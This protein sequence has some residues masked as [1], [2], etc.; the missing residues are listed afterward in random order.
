MHLY[1]HNLRISV[2]DTLLSAYPVIW[3]GRAYSQGAGVKSSQ[4][5]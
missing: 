3:L 4:S 1:T 2:V 5:P